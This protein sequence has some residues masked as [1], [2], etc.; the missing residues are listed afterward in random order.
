MDLRHAKRKILMMKLLMKLPMIVVLL[1]PPLCFAAKTDDCFA[2]IYA[3]NEGRLD[4]AIR[5]YSQ[6]I[7]SGSLSNKNLIVAHNDRGNAYGRKGEYALALADFNKVIELNPE[8][9]DAYY[10]R[11]LT[12]K[13]QQSYDQAINDYSRAIEL[14]PRYINAY[15]NRGNVYGRKGDY[16]S[17]I[18]DFDHTISLSPENASAYFNRG[19]AYYSQGQYMPAIEDLQKA[20]ELNPKYYKAYENLAW[21][22]A[23][24]PQQKYRDG[25]LAISLAKKAR[26]LREGDDT[27][28]W[29][30]LAAA[31]ARVGKYENARQYMELTIENTKGKG[32]IV[33]LQKRLKLY[34][35]GKQ[36]SD[37][38]SNKFL[39]E[40][41]SN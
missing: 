13:N 7:E 6:C 36:Y 10:N 39:L 8:D 30:V 20:I 40:K 38:I 27:G 14:N 21:L 17:A 35:A 18:I 26:F 4:M 5:L 1:L 29:E 22:R 23:T 16:E 33:E 41:S 31:Y 32:S 9:A 15:N 34:E 24:C 19:L 11:G 37:K 2:G 28:L 25:E 3:L 12:H